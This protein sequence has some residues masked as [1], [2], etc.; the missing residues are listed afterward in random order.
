[1]IDPTLERGPSR[2]MRQ[3]SVDRD[4]SAIF[5]GETKRVGGQPAAKSIATASN[6]RRRGLYMGL[7][8]LLLATAA[9]VAGITTIFV[10]PSEIAENVRSGQAAQTSSAERSPPPSANRRP[11]IVVE[12]AEP[13]GDT[14]VSPNMPRSPAQNTDTYARP[15]VPGIAHSGAV[16]H[17][18]AKL[19]RPYQNAPL[20]RPIR[21][22]VEARPRPECDRLEFEERAQCMHPQVLIAY[23]QLRRTYEEAVH[24]GADTA[25]LKKIQRRWK[26][27]EY[28]S[29]DDPDE[30][31]EDYRDLDDELHD[32]LQ[33][34][35]LGRNAP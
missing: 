12:E 6:S 2:D 27:L 25:S 32:I 11:S 24:A 20:E 8:A 9:S 29:A 35:R 16:R 18:P 1:M 15:L 30:R 22:Q 4:L 33:D 26:R 14:T 10:Q 23:R 13:A 3:T 7:G 31:I 28:N 21:A 34:S 19:E 17:Q 5:A